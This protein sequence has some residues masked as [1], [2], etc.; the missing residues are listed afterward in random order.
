MGTFIKVEDVKT[1]VNS[2]DFNDTYLDNY[3]NQD[4]LKLD[5]KIGRF[6]FVSKLYI[7]IKKYLLEP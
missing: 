2:L 6:I 3:K 4:G 1:E 5:N 7:C